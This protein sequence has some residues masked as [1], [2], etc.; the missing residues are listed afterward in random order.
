MKLASGAEKNSLEVTKPSPFAEAIEP[1]IPEF[2]ANPKKPGAGRKR[3]KVESEE[4]VGAS[5][6]NACEEERVEKEFSTNPKKQRA[7]WKR[8]KVEPM[9]E[10][11]ASSRMA[12]EGCEEE[13]AGAVK[14]MRKA[15]IVMDDS[16]VEIYDD[17]DDADVSS[18]IK[19]VVLQSLLKK[20]F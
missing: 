5:S 11:G 3:I 7:G 12:R 15:L 10:V 18:T 13:K 2:N 20:F 9:E 4:E 6:R 16:D 8:A 14:K 1:S 19:C 17:S